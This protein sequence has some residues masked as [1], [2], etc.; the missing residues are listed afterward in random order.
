MVLGPSSIKFDGSGSRMHEIR[1]FGAIFGVPEAVGAPK[2]LTFYKILKIFE[3]ILVTGA[4]SNFIISG[5]WWRGPGARMGHDGH[6]ARASSG[7]GPGARV[8]G[9]GPGPGDPIV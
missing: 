7:L 4:L 8:P 3:K 6:G 2:R 1:W 9:P 5:G